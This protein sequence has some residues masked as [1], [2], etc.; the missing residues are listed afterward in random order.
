MIFHLEDLLVLLEI[1]LNEASVLV[2]LHCSFIG[3]KCVV[4]KFVF[5]IFLPE[6]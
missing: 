4:E 5:S 2:H 1:V 3:G 6:H